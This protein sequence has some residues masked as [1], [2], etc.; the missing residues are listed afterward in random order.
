MTP[1][2]VHGREIGN[3][4]C[5]PG[6]PCQ[7][8]SLPTHGTCEAAAGF[9]FDSGHY[10]DV[11][12]SG[13]RCAMVVKWPGPIHE[14]NGTMQLIVDEN[15]S[16]EQRAALEKITLGEDT[17]EMATMWWVFSKMSPNKLETLVKPIELE[18][19]IDARRG[20]VNVPGVFGMVA[21]PITNPVTGVEHRARIHLP[22]GFEFLVGEVAK[23]TTTTQGEIDLPNNQGTHTHLVE[24]HLSNSGI[25][26][27]A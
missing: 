21:E 4:N 1:W 3:C 23:A 16:P 18:I 15:A 10:G 24:I 11:D 20:K 26:K 19:D 8:M 27:A 7:F 25:V 2:E 9:E 13:T 12:L 14:G 22:N 6:C 5:D 17:E